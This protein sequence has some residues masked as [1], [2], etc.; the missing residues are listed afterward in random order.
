MRASDRLPVG[1]KEEVHVGKQGYPDDNILR[2][3]HK[4]LTAVA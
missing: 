2:V 3:E 1:V 4:P